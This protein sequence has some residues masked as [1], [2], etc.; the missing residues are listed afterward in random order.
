M[1]TCAVLAAASLLV[2]SYA[3]WVP[4][5]GKIDLDVNN[6]SQA[7][8]A[9][10][11]TAVHLSDAQAVPVFLVRRFPEDGIN[12]MNWLN[13]GQH[14]VAHNRDPSS[15]ADSSHTS[16]PGADGPSNPI[17]TAHRDFQATGDHS[18]TGLVGV[19]A[20]G[21]SHMTT[22]STDPHAAADHLLTGGV[23]EGATGT[24]H[25]TANS[26]DPHV[27]A[28]HLHTG[29]DGVGITG[30]SHT[31]SHSNVAHATADHSHTGLAGVIASGN[32][33]MTAHSND[34]HA[35]ADN[36]HTGL[37][38]VSATGNSNM[39]AYSSDLH[40]LADHLHPNVADVDAIENP[41]TT[42]KNSKPQTSADPSFA[43]VADD[44]GTENTSGTANNSDSQ[45]AADSAVGEELDRRRRELTGPSGT[46]YQNMDDSS[47]G[48]FAASEDGES[49]NCG[50]T[51]CV[52]MTAHNTVNS[53][54]AGPPAETGGK[55][56]ENEKHVITGGSS[57]VVPIMVEPFAAV[58][59]FHKGNNEDDDQNR[60]LL[61]DAQTV[62]HD[63]VPPG[64][65]GKD[66]NVDGLKILIPTAHLSLV[67]QRI[68]R[69][70]CTNEYA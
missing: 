16:V 39:T 18:H 7:L 22:H 30:N 65:T 26:N 13:G 60:G 28:E 1:K 15:T 32:S 12:L 44:D 9:T 55:T 36:L 2:V 43:S 56:R 23:G 27:A 51:G 53:P 40:A 10:P 3:R 50:L 64:A 42:A 68:I 59:S 25:F 37:A 4:L 34:H 46:V 24:S 31:T 58:Y 33:H 41:H 49:R 20:T 70:L 63:S 48:D 66:C 14:T 61:A 62:A 52:Y 54:A 29:P 8:T 17:L 19:G 57:T 21:N 5:V 45:A 47:P 11:P 38:G 6:I 69:F 67:E 35:A